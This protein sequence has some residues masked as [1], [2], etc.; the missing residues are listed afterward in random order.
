[1]RKHLIYAAYVRESDPSLENSATIESQKQAIREYCAKEGYELSEDLIYADALSSTKIPYRKRP[2]VMKALNDGGTLFHVLLVN[3]YGRL[4]RKQTEQAV[5]IELFKEKGVAVLSCTEK[6]DDSPTGNFMRAAYAFNSEVE[7]IKIA[8]RTYRG[9]IHRASLGGR[10]LGMGR[11][12]YGYQWA[13]ATKSAYAINDC[14]FYIDRDGIRWSEYSVVVFIFDS[15]DEGWSLRR[16]RNFLLE[17]GVPT[18]TGN[19]VWGRQTIHQIASCPNYTGKAAAFRWQKVEGKQ[20]MVRRPEEETIPL[21]DGVIPAI[22]SVAQFERVQR[23]FAQNKLDS[24]RNSKYPET[25]LLKY[26]LSKCAICGRNMHLSHI[27]STSGMIHNYQCW[28]IGKNGLRCRVSLRIDSVD[29]AAW[30]WAVEHIKNPRL[31][32]DRTNQIIKNY[33]EE[34]DGKTIRQ[35]LTEV[36]RKIGNLVLLAEDAVD[37]DEIENI[38]GRISG[39]QKKKRD[40][41]RMLIDIENEEEQER[42]VRCAID[43]FLR[44]CDKIRPFLDDPAY[45]PTYADMRRAMVVLGIVAVIYPAGCKERFTLTLAPPSIMESLVASVFLGEYSLDSDSACE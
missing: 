25:G 43:E 16:I 45:I 31:V 27:A 38:R 5:L 13:D 41:E 2:Q 14:V 8:E 39:L 29:E 10:L 36:K 6:F 15:L 35:N 7:A 34:D 18:R 28:D 22:V 40:L 23:Q 17:K 37:A 4:A 24:V 30:L 11:P 20:H 26:G 1:M 42:K 44:W 3:E 9:K 12:G 32:I 21:P 19:P 33:R